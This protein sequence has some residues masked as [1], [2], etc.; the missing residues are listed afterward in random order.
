MYIWLGVLI[1]LVFTVISFKILFIILTRKFTKKVR[2]TKDDHIETLRGRL[3]QI[4]K[5]NKENK[6]EVS[7]DGKYWLGTSDDNLKIGDNAI[8]IGFND[9]IL[10]LKK[11]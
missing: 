6:F 11:I 3:V 4:R 7:I 8:I 2:G 1:F 5:I 10:I 9:L